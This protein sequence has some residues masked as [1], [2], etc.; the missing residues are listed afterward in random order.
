MNYLTEGNSTNFRGEI[1][2]NPRSDMVGME[3]IGFLHS[4]CVGNPAARYRLHSPSASDFAPWDES[5]RSAHDQFSNLVCIMQE[6][7][8]ICRELCKTKGHKAERQWCA[9]TFRNSQKLIEARLA[10]WQPRS[11]GN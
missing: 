11:K 3:N 7:Q 8:Q 2:G 9:E 5:E 10:G 1:S 6:A 4:L